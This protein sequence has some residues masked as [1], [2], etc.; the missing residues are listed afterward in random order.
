MGIL[1]SLRSGKGAANAA[2]SV[3]AHY[4]DPDQ[5]LALAYEYE[6]SGQ[7]WFWETDRRGMLTYVSRW[8]QGRTGSFNFGFVPLTIA[9]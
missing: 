6:K 7:G 5:V 8:G 2:A 4:A 1:K 9:G 3:R